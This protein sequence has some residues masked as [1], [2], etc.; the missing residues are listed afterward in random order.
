MKFE[1]YLKENLN[2]Q[3]TDTDSVKIWNKVSDRIDESKRRRRFFW[4]FGSV[5]I[6]TLIFA[7]VGYSYFSK[8]YNTELSNTRIAEQIEKEPINNKKDNYKNETKTSGTTDNQLNATTPVHLKKTNKNEKNVSESENLKTNKS[9]K[10]KSISSKIRSNSNYN[11]AEA[12][13]VKEYELISDP[14]VT[15]NEINIDLSQ[16]STLN[17]TKRKNDL[18]LI[19]LSPILL[20]KP[21]QL[22][23]PRRKY[24][25]EK[26]LA[27]LNVE[28]PANL[29]TASKIFVGLY[30]GIGL[31]HKA[32]HNDILSY[33]SLRTQTEKTLEH[34]ETELHL[35]YQISKKWSIISG[36][37]HLRQVERFNWEGDYST[38]DNG[39]Y[40]HS[41][42]LPNETDS[43]PTFKTGTHV[44]SVHRKM[45]IYNRYNILSIPLKISYAMALGKN[46][47]SITPGILY[48]AVINK[49]G[50]ILDS[51]ISPLN[52]NEIISKIDLSYSLNVQFIKQ[53][54][55]NTQLT[56][57]SNYR[58]IPEWRQVQNQSTSMVR[59]HMINLQLGIRHW[60]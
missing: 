41:I 6:I 43:I 9:K 56:I 33:S 14:H 10:T 19:A 20:N 49:K 22:T 31:S 50:Y 44:R 16:K 3:R 7:A 35:G 5:G 8:T 15:G 58:Y 1:D 60:L 13:T 30:T 47:L 27:A 21:D 12:Q 18:R 46:R 45:N 4:L 42:Y 36:I 26:T 59:Y 39:E 54:K 29:K 11:K 32:I 51:A 57:G 25:L 37:N 28:H 40:L 48:T 53:I 34:I 38:V 55:G 17:Q 24:K 23:L 2:E 52:L